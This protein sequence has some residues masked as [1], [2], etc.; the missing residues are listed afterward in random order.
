MG[1]HHKLCHVLGGSLDL[2]H[3]E[4]HAVVL[5]HVADYNLP[6]APE[7]HA[8]FTRALNTDDPA[9]ALAALGDTLGAPR[10]LSGLGVSAED[11]PKIVVE[12]LASLYPNPRPVSPEDLEKILHDA[13]AG[14]SR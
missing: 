8:A 10:T 5:P 12:V 3:A 7:A 6:L 4:T 2:P 14:P 1:L 11:L 9:S 13:W